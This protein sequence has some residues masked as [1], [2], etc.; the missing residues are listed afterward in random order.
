MYTVCEKEEKGLDL[1]WV[2]HWQVA[3]LVLPFRQKE[4]L[5][6]PVDGK[7]ASWSKWQKVK[8]L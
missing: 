4:L 1:V 6:E 5:E 8:L 7:A 2:F 3:M